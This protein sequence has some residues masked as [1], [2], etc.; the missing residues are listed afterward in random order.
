[1]KSIILLI[2]PLL[3]FSQPEVN[4]IYFAA[5]TKDCYSEF[6]SDGKQAKLFEV[7]VIP[8]VNFDDGYSKKFEFYEDG[9]KYEIRED[10]VYCPDST[11][12]QI[13]SLSETWRDSVRLNTIEYS[14]NWRK[15]EMERANELYAKAKSQGIAITDYNVNDESEYT[16]GTGYS[17]DFVNAGK[18]TIKYIWFT[19]NAYNR[20]KDFISTKVVKAMGPIKPSYSGS[21]SFSYV[22]HTDLVNTVKLTGIKIQYMDGTF[23]VAKK[24]KD[25][26]LSERCAYLLFGDP[27]E[28]NEE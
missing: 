9:I 26:F 7:Q 11:K 22:W 23:F 15:I 19:L 6:N 14:K 17:I 21:G 16:N 10:Y 13:T 5:V 28:L 12:T 18:K 3:T 27:L 24:P 4:H 25:A 20:V 1:M 8:V 2:L